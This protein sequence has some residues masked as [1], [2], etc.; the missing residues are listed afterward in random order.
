[1]LYDISGGADA[2]FVKQ[3]LVLMDCVLL[4]FDVHEI[5]TL[6]HS[7]N[8]WRSFIPD[9]S[10]TQPLLVGCKCDT[11]DGPRTTAEYKVCCGPSRYQDIG[12]VL[13]HRS[14]A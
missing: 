11:E 14:E 13:T 2:A 10:T 6:K 1:M 5:S 9:H 7:M 12:S 8:E 3:V 4:C